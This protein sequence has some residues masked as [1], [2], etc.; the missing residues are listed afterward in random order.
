[1]VINI[2]MIKKI[3]YFF[4]SEKESWEEIEKAF[5]LFDISGQGHIT[6]EDLKQIAT[7]LGETMSDDELKLMVLEANK[8]N[9]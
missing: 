6:F 9:K 2:I 5:K 1:M 4:K 8:S 3:K 7:E